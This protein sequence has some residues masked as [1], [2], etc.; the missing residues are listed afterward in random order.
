VTLVHLFPVRTASRDQVIL[1]AE[2]S[3]IDRAAEPYRMP[4]AASAAGS[5]QVGAA[6]FER[7]TF[8]PPA[9]SQS[10]SMR[11]GASDASISSPRVD[12][13]DA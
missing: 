11:P 5:L 4:K 2:Q 6:G 13:L 3:R 8:R 9:E 1:L 12:I 7:T 10:V